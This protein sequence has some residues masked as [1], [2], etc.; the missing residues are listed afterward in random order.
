MNL[1]E[2]AR[3]A[4]LRPEPADLSL[5]YIE[6][7]VIEGIYRDEY[8]LPTPTPSLSTVLGS[9]GHLPSYSA[10][11]GLCDDGL[12]FLMDLSD[13]A[14]GSIL[15]TGQPG[16]GKTR[17]LAA[18]LTSAARLN[19]PRSVS[20]CV[21]SPQLYEVESLGRFPHCQGIAPPYERTASEMIMKLAAIAEQRRSGR[22]LGPAIILAIDD[23]AYLAGEYLDYG[24]SVHLKWLL[25]YGPASMVWPVV[26]LRSD[27]FHA[28]DRRLLGS[29]STKV[30]G[31]WHFEN[32][33]RKLNPGGRTLS[34]HL[35]PE[36]T[37]EVLFNNQWIRF[38]VPSI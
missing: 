28:V 27:Q 32:D 18:L 1:I 38:A 6:G 14:P 9:L 21:I 7:E 19:D 4:I 2:L 8:V 15:I 3:N 29:F 23:L 13:P 31:Q 26:T 35:L 37:F 24:V 20:F 36:G 10:L 12:P 33:P 34:R 22:E 25:H 16:S 5:P 11:L 30:L 17:L